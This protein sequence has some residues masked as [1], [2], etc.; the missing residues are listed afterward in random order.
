[1]PISRERFAQGLTAQEFI[2]KMTKNQERFQD[3][4]EK[5]TAV[6]TDEDR[7]FFAEHPVSIAAI[8]EDW[9]TDVIQFLP[10]GIKL[11]EAFDLPFRI[12]LRDENL[13]LIDQYLKEGKYRSI[14]VFVLYDSDWNELGFFTERPDSVTQDMA[15]ESRRFALENSDLDGVNRTYE[16]MPDETRNKIREN[17]SSFRWNNMLDWNRRC[18]DDLKEIAASATAGAAR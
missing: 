11:A 9:C 3:N 12:F 14:P 5:T 8:G 4:L 10:V 6:F 17:S 2:D 18:V 13:D 16:N 15:K 1:M 7:A